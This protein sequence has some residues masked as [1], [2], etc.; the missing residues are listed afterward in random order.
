MNAKFT[1]SHVVE[2]IMGRAE[3]S[4]NHKPQTQWGFFGS[5]ASLLCLG[6]QHYGRYYVTTFT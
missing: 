3:K 4:T 1:R 5:T 2:R 6:V